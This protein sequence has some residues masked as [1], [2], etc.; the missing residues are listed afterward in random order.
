MGSQEQPHVRDLP[1]TWGALA[2]PSLRRTVNGLPLLL[3]PLFA[4]F[5]CQVRPAA[6]WMTFRKSPANR[7]AIVDSLPLMC[8]FYARSRLTPLSSSLIMLL[9]G[10]VKFRGVVSLIVISLS[11]SF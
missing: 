10:A 4:K 7:V 3:Q 8:L 6:G 2:E 11:H 9:I 1:V 5:R